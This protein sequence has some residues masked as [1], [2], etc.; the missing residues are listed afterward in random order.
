MENLEQLGQA[1]VDALTATIA[2][3]EQDGTI[4]AVNE[5]WKRFAQENRGSRDV[6]STGVGV[7]YLEVCKKAQGAFA[8][9]ALPALIGIQHVLQGK[10]AAFQLEYPCHSPTE[11]R[12]FLM[13]VTP[14][15]QSGGA[16]IAH[17]NITERKL[18]EEA[19]QRSEARVRRLI[20]S[21]I[22]GIF[23]WRGGQITEANDI[24]LHLL[25]FTR[26]ELLIGKLLWNDITPKQFE[27]LD[28]KALATM[29]QLGALPVP[30]EKELVRKDGRCI[31]VLIGTAFVDQAQQEGV[32]YVLDISERK[33][34]EQRKDEFFSMVS[35]ELKTPLS[36]MRI[37]TNLL[38]RQLTEQGFRDS[39]GSLVHL[40]TQARQ[41][42][43]LLTD[44]LEVSQLQAGYL[45]YTE[46]AVDMNA[47]VREVVTILQQVSPDHV[48]VITGTV[49]KPMQGD[50]ARLGQVLSNLL[51]N[52]IKYSVGT[53]PINVLLS[54]TNEQLT[55]RV[56]DEGIGIP[57][58]EQDKIFERY[59]RVQ[60]GRQESFPGF[61]LGLHISQEII[62]RHGGTIEV[63][64]VE[65]KGSAFTIMLPFRR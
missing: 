8:E 64:S 49:D 60:Y 10:Q 56:R 24:F 26:Q 11:Q 63:E 28:R 7:N 20:E 57:T 48:I 47:L 59:Y 43:K 61:G 50:R 40:A 15:N 37:L 35:H 13:S 55:I 32:A 31:P 54:S 23:F 33:E 53:Y 62:K 2:V 41:L 58:E 46:E 51:T 39:S 6:P 25:G 19:V 29:R 5:A 27:A 44:L 4:R 12:W 9:E 30:Y 36:N 17:L 1:V 65:G 14:L 22:L 38:T 45:L 34:L 18:A 52:A 42:M 3:I 21:N 16:V